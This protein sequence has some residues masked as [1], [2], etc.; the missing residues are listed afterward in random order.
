M[1]ELLE[2]AIERV[3]SFPPKAQDDFARVLLRLTGEETEVVALTE[4]EQAAIAAS[5]AAAAR[6]DFATDEEVRAVWATYG[7]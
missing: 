1:T 6:G 3:R 2:K 5:K 7:L 4:D